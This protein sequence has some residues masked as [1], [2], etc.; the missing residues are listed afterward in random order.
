[1][2]LLQMFSPIKTNPD[3]SGSNN[4]IYHVVAWEPVFNELSKLH[5]S[6]SFFIRFKMKTLG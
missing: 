3:E 2:E 1:M 5:A 4:I 6:E